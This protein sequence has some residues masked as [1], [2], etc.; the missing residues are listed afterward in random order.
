MM[1]SG[2][3]I[4]KP[5]VIIVLHSLIIHRHGLRPFVV[6]LGGGPQPGGV[7]HPP[8]PRGWLLGEVHAIPQIYPWSK[9]IRTLEDLEWF[10]PSERN[11]LHPLR[12]VLLLCLWMSLS[13]ASKSSPPLEFFSNERLPFIAQGRRVHRCWAPIGGPNELPSPGA[14]APL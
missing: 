13:S 10:G 5:S 9:D 2:F 4:L 11:T 8:N 6:A 3:K 12:V 7:V 1:C 14:I